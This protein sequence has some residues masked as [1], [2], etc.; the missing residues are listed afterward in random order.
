MIHR[1]DLKIVLLQHSNVILQKQKMEEKR[2]KN[3]CDF[4]KIISCDLWSFNV[5]IYS[6]IK[7]LHFTYVV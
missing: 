3:Y 2:V 5:N 1:L 7:S 6:G 4:N